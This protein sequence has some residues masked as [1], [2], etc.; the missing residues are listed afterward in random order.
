MQYGQHNSW[1]YGLNSMQSSNDN[2]YIY[3]HNITSGLLYSAAFAPLHV[4]LY[5][6]RFCCKDENACQIDKW[7]LFLNI[8]LHIRCIEIDYGIVSVFFFAQ[9]LP[10]YVDVL[11]SFHRL[12]NHARKYMRTVLVVRLILKK[13]ILCISYIKIG[14]KY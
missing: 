4:L 11:F 7:L 8:R 13:Y 12:E 14:S 9:I 2:V 1:C 5:R 10:F 6:N 3:L